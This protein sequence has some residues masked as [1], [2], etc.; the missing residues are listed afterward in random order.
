MFYVAL[1]SWSIRAIMPIARV[2]FGPSGAQVSH[3]FIL[4]LDTTRVNMINLGVDRRS[5][6]LWE[7]V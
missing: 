5:A 3:S 2:E 6:I 7:A 1:W 4:P